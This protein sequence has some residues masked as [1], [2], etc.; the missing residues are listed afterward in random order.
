MRDGKLKPN[1]NI[2]NRSQKYFG[3]PSS[4]SHPDYNW[5]YR[6]ALIRNPTEPVYTPSAYNEKD[7]YMYVNPLRLINEVTSETSVQDMRISGS[8]I[9]TR[10]KDLNIKLRYAENKLNTLSAYAEGF[11]YSTTNGR[12]GLCFLKRGTDKG[13]PDERQCI[14]LRHQGQRHGRNHRWRCRHPISSCVCNRRVFINAILWS[15]LLHLTS[16]HRHL[17]NQPE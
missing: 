15:L 4:Q 16:P 10:V 6:Q 12:R 9:L 8:A 17:I 11:N 5:I 2:I 3:T 14:Q 7:V 13:R 1:A